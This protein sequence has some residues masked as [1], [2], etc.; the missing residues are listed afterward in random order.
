MPNEASLHPAPVVI[1]IEEH[2]CGREIAER[3]DPT[4]Q[5]RASQFR[6][7]LEDMGHRRLQEM[8]RTGID[9]QV[10]S[11]VSPAVQRFDAETAVP[12]ARRANDRLHASIKI[13]AQRLPPLQHCRLRI[14]A[15]PLMS[16][17]GRSPRS[18]SRA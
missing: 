14:L 3:I 15:Q 4:G 8:E 12:L 11:H 1:A 16:W 9:V 2:Y 5:I 13:D 10:L 7:H 17:S 6:E 18:A